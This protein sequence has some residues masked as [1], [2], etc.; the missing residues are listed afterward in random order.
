MTVNKNKTYNNFAY[1][2][3][4]FL[5]KYLPNEGGVSK[6]TIYSYRDT[7]KLFIEF[8]EENGVKPKNLSFEQFTRDNILKFLDWLESSK[9]NKV[10]TRNVRL[11][12]LHSFS[13]Y[14][15][16]EN[17]ELIEYAH[18][19]LSIKKK[20]TQ[21]S[22]VG[23]ISVDEM[24]LIIKKSK[25]NF[26]HYVIICVLYETG[27]RVQELCDLKWFDIKL[28][29][30][31]TIGVLG[32]GNKKRIIP[33]SKELKE[34]LVKYKENYFH[35]NNDYLFQNHS[36]DKFTREG[37]TFILK[38]YVTLAKADKPEWYK[39]NVT[40]HILRH[41]RAMA[42]LHS[43]VDLIYIRDILGHVEIKTTEIYARIDGEMKRKAL[44][45]ANNIIDDNIQTDW[46]KNKDLLKWLN[47]LKD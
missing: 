4:N 29:Y 5:G 18:N 1:A 24:K 13:N 41:S 26:I 15:L 35:D 7:F 39:I 32:K 43:G 19:I 27:C 2:L 25:I 44:L 38:K 20:K 31:P 40:P 16:L 36:K 47:S 34:L 6:N 37:I 8:N 3:T 33:I 21:Q 23:Y 30:P 14:I 10:S 17:P 11:A 28:E 46:N 45:K 9:N 12:A 22:T 42:L